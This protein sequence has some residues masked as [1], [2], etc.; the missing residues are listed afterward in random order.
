MGGTSPGPRRIRITQ[1]VARRIARWT[2]RLGAERLHDPVFVVGFNN[3][4]K[5]TVVDLLAQRP[6]LLIYP[7]EGNGELWFPDFF[8]WIESSVDVGPIWSDPHRFIAAVMARRSDGFLSARAQ[9][10]AYQWLNGARRLINDSGMLAAVAPDTLGMFP[11]ARYIH[12]V[13]DGRLSSYITARIE[14][15]RIIRSPRKYLAYGCPINFSGVLERMAQYW[16][17]TMD[18]M[19]EVKMRMPGQVLELRYE[20]WWRQPDQGVREILEFLD[21]GSPHQP[22]PPPLQDLSESL[23]AEM[24]CAEVEL[25][26]RTIGPALARKGYT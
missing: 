25:L 10:G 26:E 16:A 4:G 13:R 23:R 21:L 12:F 22:P 11:D 9:L 24:T 20:E 6:E 14:W 17:W 5:S 1:G 15:S 7:G 8:P 19:D 3:C 18:R 2:P